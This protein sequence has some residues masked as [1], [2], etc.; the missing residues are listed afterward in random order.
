[1]NH[2]PTEF[3]GSELAS[4][5]DWALFQGS[6]GWDGALDEGPNIS[7][8]S[9]MA[10]YRGSREQKF[11][12][13]NFSGL[14]YETW[15]NIG[16]ESKECFHN[17]FKHYFNTHFRNSAWK[18][19]AKGSTWDQLGGVIVYE[20]S[21]SGKYSQC[22]PDAVSVK[23]LSSHIIQTTD[24]WRKWHWPSCSSTTFCWEILDSGIYMWMPLD[25]KHSSKHCSTWWHWSPQYDHVCCHTANT[26]QEQ[27]QEHDKEL[28]VS[29]WPQRYPEPNVT[30]HP[31]EVLIPG[32]RECCYHE[33]DLCCLKQC[34]GG[35]I[36]QKTIQKNA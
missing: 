6:S 34:L 22:F 29:T 13:L 19:W 4:L 8:R 26:A 10:D 1:M 7:T 16:G 23:I 15:K 36:D 2:L 11:S 14:V 25:T 20:S 3:Q 35:F 24:I 32:W 18:I 12:G 21:S 27:P 31:W 33:G 5:V 30:E 17:R 9:S 28:S